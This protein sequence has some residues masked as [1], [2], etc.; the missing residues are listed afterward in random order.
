MDSGRILYWIYLWE[1]EARGE[2]QGGG[3]RV[4]CA[5]AVPPVESFS[6]SFDHLKNPITVVE[7][8]LGNKRK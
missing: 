2:V 5:L 7:Q 3:S 4:G 8:L 1:V 6:H